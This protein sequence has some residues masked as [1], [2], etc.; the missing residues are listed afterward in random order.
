MDNALRKK[1]LELELETQPVK[2]ETPRV[3]NMSKQEKLLYNRKMMQAVE[4]GP[5]SKNGNRYGRK[6]RQLRRA[7]QLVL[8]EHYKR[9]IRLTR[10]RETSKN[11]KKSIPIQTEEDQGADSLKVDAGQNNSKINGAKKSKHGRFILILWSFCKGY[12]LCHLSFILLH[13]LHIAEF[14]VKKEGSRLL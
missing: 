7:Y 8:A 10:I 13:F 12:F 5:K 4:S 11:G 2:V 3:E 9:M 6:E 14:Q 1:I